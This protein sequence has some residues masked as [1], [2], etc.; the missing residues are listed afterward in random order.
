M[1]IA[2]D[3]RKLTFLYQAQ[4][5]YIEYTILGVKVLTFQHNYLQEYI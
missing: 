2:T 1:L 3:T 4:Y 5:V